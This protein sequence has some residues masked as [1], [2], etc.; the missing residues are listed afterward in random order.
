LVEGKQKDL[1]GRMV[2]WLAHG[3][4]LVQF[5]LISGPVWLQKSYFICVFCPF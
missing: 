3:L 1:G 4:A 5:F 2:Q